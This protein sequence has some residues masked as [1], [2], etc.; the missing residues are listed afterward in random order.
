MVSVEQLIPSRERFLNYVRT[1][2]SDPALAEDILQD[3]LLK[4]LRKT[5]E[6]RDEQRLV[7][8]FYRVLHNAIVD[9]YRSKKL[10]SNTV[11]ISEADEVVVPEIEH[12]ELCKC[13]YGLLPTINPDYADLIRSELKYE[14][15][16]SESEAARLGITTNNLKVRRHRARQALRKRLEE[17][18]RTCSEHSCLDCTCSSS[19]HTD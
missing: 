16:D 7:P 1:R 6:L 9:T 2:V 10:A 17:T 14:D 11:E 8:W 18:C 19:A 15:Q 12:T 5:P 4:A 3:S 13:F